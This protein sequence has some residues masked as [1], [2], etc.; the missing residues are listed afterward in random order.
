MN[1]STIKE[2][3][4]FIGVCLAYAFTLGVIWTK[5]VTK[6]NGLGGR[7]KDV[8]RGQSANSARI[9][10]FAV[11][12]AE[13][14]S[15]AREVNSRMSRMEKAVEDVHDEIQQGNLQLGSQLAEISRA[16]TKMDKDI[17][18]RLVRV[19]TLAKVESKLGPLPT[20]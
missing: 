20:D 18:G 4:A 17:S 8:E 9:E 1:P 16:V 3:A 11:Q 6:V 19:E 13:Y 2:W 14:R 12:L 5:M 7:V 10:A 15:D